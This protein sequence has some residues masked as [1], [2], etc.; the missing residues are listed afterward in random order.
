MTAIK[1]NGMNNR[2]REEALPEGKARQAV[3]VQFGNDGE[4]LFSRPGTTRV[5][6]GNCHSLH[7]GDS[8]IF[9]E[10][11]NLKRLNSDNTATT[12]RASIGSN[13]VFYTTVGDATYWANADATGVVVAGVNKE[14]GVARPARQADA[15]P[16]SSGGM[17]AGEYRLAITWLGSDGEEGG[18]GVSK[19]VIVPEGGGIHLTNFPVP[20]AYCTG[21]C[22]YLSSVNSKDL[23][24]YGEFAPNVSDIA[25]VKRLCTIPL[26]TQF[27][28]PPQPNAKI[29]AHNGRIY[30]TRDNR[31]H[32]TDV[33]KYGSQHRNQ[34]F[35]FDSTAKVI[36]SAPPTL[37]V[38]TENQLHQ[39]VG[40][41][42]PEGAQLNLLQKG[43]CALGSEASDPD[44]L[45]DY[46]MS[47]RGFIALNAQGI[48]GLLSYDNVAIPAYKTGA[49]VVT[50]VDGLKYALFVGK[51][52]TANPLA[53]KDWQAA[54]LLRNA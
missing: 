4:V 24:L 14:W 54:E 13:C 23:Y 38:N 49:M 3:N 45:T 7:Q 37:Y 32:Y 47:D 12:L 52:A 20:P 36:V 1:F 30:Y 28:Y 6:A 34:F 53:N 19:R 22:V 46:L 33:H 25:L 29:I 50:E 51:D 2:A 18:T 26:T 16:S 11:G 17:F 39:I 8:T 41:D 35:R 44:G 27:S 31:V 5:Y 48:V 9:V 42:S 15:A 10:D 43:G 21:V 40:I